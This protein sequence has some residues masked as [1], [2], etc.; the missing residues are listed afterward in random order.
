MN[1]ET[2]LPPL[3][4]PR[5]ADLVELT[6]PRITLMVVVTAAVGFLLADNASGG[7]N[8]LPL[9][10]LF[11]TLFGTGMVAASG[12]A[13]NQVIERDLD[14]RMAR[15]SRR[16]LPARRLDPE[17][18][19]AF[20]VLL[21]LLGLAYLD[22]LVN[23]LTAL[24]GASTLAGYLFVYTPLK[25]VSSLA[26]IVGAAPGAVPPL[27]GWAGYANDLAPGAWAMF[28]IL[29]VWQLPHFLAIAWMYRADYAQGGYPMLPVV[30]PAGG[31][32]ARQAVLWA[33][34]LVPLSLLPSALGLTGGVYAV[35]A[36]VLGLAYLAASIAFGVDPERKSAR[37][38]LLTSVLYLPAL[39]VVMLID[40]LV[41]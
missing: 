26:T 28:G 17:L 40:R 2:Q 39:L 18:A 20:G 29:F 9:G 36:F 4:F 22:F 13:L 3:P 24:L 10:L 6:K 11:H 31:A 12:S 16:P 7:E 35:G 27:M 19:L 15:T 21:G 30:R 23:P 14:G 38:L 1:V 37:R 25:R 34:A 33:A 5:F 32:T 8:R 41:A